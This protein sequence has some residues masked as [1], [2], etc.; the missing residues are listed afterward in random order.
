MNEKKIAYFAIDEIEMNYNEIIKDELIEMKR[1]FFVYQLI[2]AR[3]TKN[4]LGGAIQTRSSSRTDIEPTCIKHTA[5]RI[6]I[7]ACTCTCYGH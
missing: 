4:Y 2:V 6:Y 7:A 1:L 5:D 3:A